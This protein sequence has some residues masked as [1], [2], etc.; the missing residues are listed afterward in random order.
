MVTNTKA[1]NGLVEN[2]LVY[3]PIDDIP[4]RIFSPMNDNLN[5]FS[6]FMKKGIRCKVICN[7]CWLSCKS[8][9][10][11]AWPPKLSYVSSCFDQICSPYERSL[12]YMT[13]PCKYILF[14][15]LPR[16]QI[17]IN[18]TTILWRRYFIYE[19]SGLVSVWE[20][21]EQSVPQTQCREV[22]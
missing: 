18:K 11:I 9:T 2:I 17:T 4:D 8:F 19:W 12:H 21:N 6:L 10:C 22:L 5:V 7:T 3:H 15:T 13:S 16:Y 1:S 14:L 20:S